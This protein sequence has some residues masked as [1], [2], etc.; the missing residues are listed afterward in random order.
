MIPFRRRMPNSI[1]PTSMANF[2]RQVQGAAGPAGRSRPPVPGV[3]TKGRGSDKNNRLQ[4]KSGAAKFFFL[5]EPRFC[6]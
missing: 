2:L 5:P 4:E 1:M 3:F 6:G